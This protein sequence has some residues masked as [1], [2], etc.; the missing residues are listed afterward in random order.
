MA[1][2]AR[3]LQ[4]TSR[5]FGLSIGLLSPPVREELT[6]AYLLFRVADTLED[7]EHGSRGERADALTQLLQL[8][9]SPRPDQAIA[10]AAHCATWRPS[11]HQGY[12]DLL[13]AT[14][15]LLTAIDQLH[16]AARKAIFHHAARTIRGMIQFVERSEPAGQLQLDSL[17]SL[18]Q[19]CY[20]VAGIV[21]ELITELFLLHYPQL[22]DWQVPLERDAAAFGEGL[23]LVN[24]LK[25]AE[26]DA[27]CGRRYLPADV[28]SS[29]IFGLA[30]D[31]LQR[32]EAYIGA[33]REAGAPPECVA[34]AELLTR[35]AWK[36]L[37]RVQQHGAGAKLDR[38]E[39]ALI[40]SQVQRQVEH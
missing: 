34:F 25:D 5:T 22:C 8:V 33:L 35:L 2:F 10:F 1:D 23:Q 38:R 21:G 27:Q 7:A 31:N 36:T 13:E 18:R 19:Y 40:V 6:L 24:I 9:Q 4:R 28:P 37:D 15:E 17:D 30:R 16:P 20:V 14:P 3:H 29:Q 12:L 39:V 32:A 26:A 11:R